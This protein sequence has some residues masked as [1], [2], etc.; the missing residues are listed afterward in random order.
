VI[1]SLVV[2]EIYGAVSGCGSVDPTD[3]SNYST[4][5]IVN[6]TSA[7]VVLDACRGDY[8]NPEALP[9]QLAPGMSFDDHAA[10]AATGPDMTSW[11]VKSV[12][13]RILGY[14]AVDSPRSSTGLVY[15]VSHASANRSTP[16]RQG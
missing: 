9:T 7:P 4:V 12:G 11:R 2:G 6:D 3:P 15:D 8:C 1:G 14:V 16:T 5:T 10:C 13:G